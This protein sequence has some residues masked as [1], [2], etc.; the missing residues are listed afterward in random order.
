M[1]LRRGGD[2]AD[3]FFLAMAEWQLG[4]Q[5]AAREWYKKAVEWLAAKPAV[6]SELTRFRAE[7][8]ELLGIEPSATNAKSD[9][10]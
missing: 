9:V 2:P 1:E 6:N 3:W 10:E 8:G 7:A 4:N 5:S